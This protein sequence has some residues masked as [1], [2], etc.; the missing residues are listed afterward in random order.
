M[1]TNILTEH[2]FSNIFD[3]L[4]AKFSVSVCYFTCR[5]R[6]TKNANEPFLL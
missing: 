1:K 3:V 5:H 6:F 4:I 2:Q